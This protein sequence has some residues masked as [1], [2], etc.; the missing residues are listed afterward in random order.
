[1]APIRPLAGVLLVD[2]GVGSA[3]PVPQVRFPEP[4]VDLDVQP[5]GLG[6]DTRC[7]HRALQVGGDHLGDVPVAGHRGD[8]VVHVQRRAERE[9]YALDRLFLDAPQ[10]EVDGVEQVD[11]GANWDPDAEVDVLDVQTIDDLP[12]AGPEPDV[13]EL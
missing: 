7:L 3:L 11:R 8:V 13:D 12:L 5:P 6:D 4:G 9:Y 2:L 10:I 1:M